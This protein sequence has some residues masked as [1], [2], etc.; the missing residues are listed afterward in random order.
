MRADGVSIM[1]HLHDPRRSGDAKRST[2]A[3]RQHAEKWSRRGLAGASWRPTTNC[4]LMIE[5][6]P[7]DVQRR[8]VPNLCPQQDGRSQM[9]QSLVQ[10]SV[11]QHLRGDP[12]IDEAGIAPESFA[13]EPAPE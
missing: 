10:D 6:A 8:Q 12:T 11:P 4:N 13:K 3:G 5:T 2:R 1:P 9:E 7:A